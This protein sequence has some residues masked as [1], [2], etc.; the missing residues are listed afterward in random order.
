MVS[1]K[2][3]VMFWFKLSTSE[4]EKEN[5]TEGG[6]HFWNLIFN[7]GSEVESRSSA[8]EGHWSRSPVIDEPG[9][10]ASLGQQ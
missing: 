4:D 3:P 2:S 5:Q 6:C 8:A 1:H 7:K 9:A 10:G